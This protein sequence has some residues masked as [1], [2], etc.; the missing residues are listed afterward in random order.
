M[1]IN[2][3]HLEM[4]KTQQETHQAT[5]EKAVLENKKQNKK[6]NVV[7]CKMF[8]MKP[9]ICKKGYLNVFP[10]FRHKNRTD[11]IGCSE[12]SPMSL[13][14]ILH[15]NPFLPPCLNLENFHQGNKVFL[16]E[17]DPETN[18]PLPCF[19]E[20]QKLMY[21]DETP[22]RHK[23]TA[24]HNHTKN[25][26]IPLYSIWT[27]ASGERVQKTY[28]ESRQF[29]CNY[30]E[31]LATVTPEFKKLKQML[32]DGYNLQICGYDGYEIIDS[33]SNHY[34]DISRPF[35]HELVLY[36]LLTIDDVNEY[37]WRVFKTEEF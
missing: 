29:Y 25:K 11:G 23:P 18:E 34:Q 37:P 32:N 5:V 17:V 22:H 9:V 14:P 33:I 19:F 15:P 26:N 12:L 35:G 10:N 31:R 8:M 2:P 7:C 13:G 3:N 27:R 30:Y 20:T 4:K 28:L 24:V 36:T 1:P 6:G 16:S 21:E